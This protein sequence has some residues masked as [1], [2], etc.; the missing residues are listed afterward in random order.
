MTLPPLKFD[1]E[2]RE[3]FDDP[4][5]QWVGNLLFIDAM[6]KVINWINSIFRT[7]QLD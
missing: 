7:M 5:H 4:I 3:E 1:T 2:D 6:D